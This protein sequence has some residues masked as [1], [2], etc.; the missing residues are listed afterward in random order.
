LYDA[1]HGLEREIRTNPGVDLR[2]DLLYLEDVLRI[3]G[4]P[5]YLGRKRTLLN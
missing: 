4:N 5:G 2:D 1:Y 3:T